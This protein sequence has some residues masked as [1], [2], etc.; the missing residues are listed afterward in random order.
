MESFEQILASG[1]KANS[2]GRAGEVVDIVLADPSRLSEL[3]ACISADDAWVRMRAIDSFEKLIK[4][5]PQ[6]VTPFLPKIFSD[7]VLRDQPSIQW[8]LA[9][10]FTEVQLSDAQREQAISWLKQRLKTTDVDWIVAADSMKAML[11]F[12]QAGRVT[13]IEI[14]PLFRLQQQH[15]SKSVRRKAEKLLQELQDA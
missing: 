14:E 12:Y 8:H 3:F 5:N 6:W 13:K 15:A 7:L 4:G 2:L 10:I 11:Y 9:Q 1:G